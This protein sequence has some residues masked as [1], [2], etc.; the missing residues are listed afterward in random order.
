[1]FT[2][3]LNN[4]FENNKINYIDEFN[5]KC[6]VKLEMYNGK[7][8]FSF[9]IKDY[10]M[11]K[12]ELLSNIEYINDD[13]L[14]KYEKYL[15]DKNLL[16]PTED[17]L[18]DMLSLIYKWNSIYSML[19]IFENIHNEYVFNQY[20]ELIKSRDI[21]FYNKVINDKNSLEDKIVLVG[22][23]I[24]KDMS[25]KFEELQGIDGNISSLIN[26]SLSKER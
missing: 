17:I 19:N 20:L 3:K 12:Y 5:T 9:K 1:M 15:E 4:L 2:I 21:K 11:F 8:L 10:P 14:D 13:F 18:K 6:L 7:V 23:Y 25:E 26:E 24:L 22:N 16:M